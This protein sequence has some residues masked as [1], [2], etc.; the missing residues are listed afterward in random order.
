MGQMEQHFVNVVGCIGVDQIWGHVQQLTASLAGLTQQPHSP[1][2][3]VRCNCG[4]V[5]YPVP[6][7]TTMTGT[8]TQ[9]DAEQAKLTSALIEQRA[10][11]TAGTPTADAQ[12]HGLTWA[13]RIALSPVAYRC[14]AIQLADNR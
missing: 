1:D 5:V 4:C 14:G 11:S 9:C 13:P 7:S 3:G 10:A 12:L 2:G 8:I 6:D